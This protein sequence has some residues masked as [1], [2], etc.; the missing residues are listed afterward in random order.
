MITAILVQSNLIVV[1]GFWWFFSSEE[2]E[3]PS[4]VAETKQFEK[5]FAPFEITEVESKFLSE[6][7]HYL[8][9]LPKLD[10][11]NL[12]VSSFPCKNASCIF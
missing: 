2:E 6:A 8:N 5:V 9:N 7:S 11:C 12:L 1:D 4:E 10:Q 3:K